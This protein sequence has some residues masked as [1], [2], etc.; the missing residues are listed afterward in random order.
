[1]LS[2]PVSSPSRFS[3]KRESSAKSV[4]STS[5]KNTSIQMGDFTVLGVDKR[6]FTTEFVCSRRNRLAL[7]VTILLQLSFFL[8]AALVLSKIHLRLEGDRNMKFFVAEYVFY[9]GTTRFLK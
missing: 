6:P 4:F 1:M 2:Q 7:I 3:P 8:V 9:W 5:T